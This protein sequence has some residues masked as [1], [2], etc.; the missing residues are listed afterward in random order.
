MKTYS[1][2]I[3]KTYMNDPFCEC[4]ERWLYTFKVKSVR[5]FLWF[6]VTKTELDF[7]KS[8]RHFSECIDAYNTFCRM[9]CYAPLYVDINISEEERKHANAT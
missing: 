6:W 2:I 4:G 1:A 3:H 7:Y 8:S 5:K 9:I